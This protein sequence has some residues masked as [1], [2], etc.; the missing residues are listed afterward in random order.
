LT[1][2]KDQIN[3]LKKDKHLS[4]LRDVE[5]E[6]WLEVIVPL[7]SEERVI[8]GVRVLRF[9]KRGPKLFEQKEGEV[10]MIEREAGLRMLKRWVQ[11]SPA[12]QTEALL[13]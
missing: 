4:S 13:I 5:G 1:L 6:K 9:L 7:H 11:E 12:D 3:R 2:S 10:A 8:G